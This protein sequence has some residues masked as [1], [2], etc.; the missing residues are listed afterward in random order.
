MKYIFKPHNFDFYVTRIL[1]STAKCFFDIAFIQ[2][3]A[4]SLQPIIIFNSCSHL[5]LALETSACWEHSSYLYVSSMLHQQL[6]DVPQK[7]ADTSKTIFFVVS[8]TFTFLLN[9]FM[10]TL[11]ACFQE[12]ISWTHQGINFVEATV[13]WTVFNHFEQ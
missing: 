5:K 12:N 11:S 4:F 6:A 8:D 2:P 3:A 7:K 9:E 10:P 1:L 13:H